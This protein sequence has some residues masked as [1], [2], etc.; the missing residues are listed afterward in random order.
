MCKWN[1]FYH[2]SFYAE[3]ANYKNASKEPIRQIIFLCQYDLNVKME[4]WRPVIPGFH[5]G[6]GGILN[7]IPSGYEKEFK[8]N[9]YNTMKFAFDKNSRIIIKQG[10][11]IQFYK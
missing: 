4:Q 3:I 11:V 2:I 10:S 6:T 5:Q 7:L 9:N 8:H 1:I